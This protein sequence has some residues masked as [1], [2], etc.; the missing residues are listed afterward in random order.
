M[1][2][3][4]S[5]NNIYNQEEIKLTNILNDPLLFLLLISDRESRD[6]SRGS[7][8]N[9]LGEYINKHSLTFYIYN[10]IVNN[11]ILIL[12]IVLFIYLL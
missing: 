8:V 12:H 4:N 1:T 6:I 9:Q 11:I 7:A 3:Q 10:F 2:Q 5:K